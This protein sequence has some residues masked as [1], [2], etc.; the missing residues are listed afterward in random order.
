MQIHELLISTLVLGAALTGCL[1]IEEAPSEAPES[2]SVEPP[3]RFPR[4]DLPPF[5]TPTPSPSPYPRHPTIPPFD[6]NRPPL[7]Q[8]LAC[9]PNGFPGPPAPDDPHGG[10]YPNR[11]GKK[12]PPGPDQPDQKCIACHTEE[13][14]PV[15]AEVLPALEL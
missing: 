8:C 4:P 14:D 7:E 10:N 2:I 3:P 5:P 12:F 13:P 6:P 9:H 11:R 15:E 1:T